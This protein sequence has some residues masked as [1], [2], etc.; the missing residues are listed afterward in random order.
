ME[1]LKESQNKFLD[2]LIINFLEGFKKY[3]SNLKNNEDDKEFHTM[4]FILSYITTNNLID[5]TTLDKYLNG[6]QIYEVFKKKRNVL[7]ELTEKNKVQD[8]GGFLEILLKFIALFSIFNTAVESH[9]TVDPKA[10][11]SST[12]SLGLWKIDSSLIQPFKQLQNPDGRCALI[13]ALISNPPEQASQITSEFTAYYEKKGGFGWLPEIINPETTEFEGGEIFTERGF[14]KDFGSKEYVGIIGLTFGL[15]MK[16]VMDNIKKIMDDV[17]SQ[18]GYVDGQIYM[19]FIGI[20]G[21]AETL[22]IRKHNEKTYYGILETNLISLIDFLSAVSE[23]PQPSL[24]N[25]TIPSLYTVTPGF[26]TQEEL[27]SMR[28]EIYSNIVNEID[29]PVEHVAENIVGVDDENVLIGIYLELP[30]KQNPL[31]T[32]I[33]ALVLP[34]TTGE[35]LVEL[36]NKM[37]LIRKDIMDKAKAVSDNRAKASDTVVDPKIIEERRLASEA[38]RR[39]LE[40]PV[41]LEERRLAREARTLAKKEGKPRPVPGDG[42]GRVPPKQVTEEEL[43]ERLKKY[44]SDNR[45]REKADREKAD[46]YTDEEPLLATAEQAMMRRDKK[47]EMEQSLQPLQ[48]ANRFSALDAD[49]DVDEASVSKASVDKSYKKQQKKDKQ[50]KDR[51]GK[52]DRHNDLN[53]AYYKSPGGGN[54]KTKTRRRNKT[55]RRNNSK[56]KKRNKTRRRN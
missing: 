53:K 32:H 49:A 35:K 19:S 54:K 39:M 20:P 17:F 30:T 22:I 51:E 10:L 42:N 24:T 9:V 2:A 26:F 1:N 46:S 37:A 6:N 3:T 25:V 47:Y 38:M 50:F 52:R 55:K 13:Q 34:Y 44:H 45:E 14:T 29:N 11:T 16:Y 33:P 40:D 12:R 18:P 27:T 41:I 43:E 7:N 5:N 15:I 56:T 21:H 31:Q 8:G 23:S 28:T 4:I 36:G 48:S